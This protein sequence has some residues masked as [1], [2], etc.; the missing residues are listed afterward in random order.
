M[1]KKSRRIMNRAKMRK[2]GFFAPT[3]RGVARNVIK[4]RKIFCRNMVKEKNY[5]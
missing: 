5:S 2:L 3:S 1:I 4:F